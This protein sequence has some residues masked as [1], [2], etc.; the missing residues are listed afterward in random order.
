M[1]K[2]GG[3][4]GRRGLLQRCIKNKNTICH[5]SKLDQPNNISAFMNVV[6]QINGRACWLLSNHYEYNAYRW[7]SHD[8]NSPSQKVTRYDHER[9]LG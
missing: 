4:R 8:V 5:S 9:S 2:L 3:R 7:L 1:R 6:F